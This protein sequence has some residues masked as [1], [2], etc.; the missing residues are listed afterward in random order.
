MIPLRNISL[1]LYC[2]P[3]EDGI[4]IA[5]VTAVQTCALPILR[6]AFRMRRTSRSLPAGPSASKRWWLKRRVILK[7]YF[8]PTRSEERRVGKECRTR[9]SRMYL[10]ER[11]TKYFEIPVIRITVQNIVP[12]L[13]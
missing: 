13:Q 4:R 1:Y 7:Q 2:C 8:L 3:A 5:D 12:H 10:N 6:S 9:E 11:L